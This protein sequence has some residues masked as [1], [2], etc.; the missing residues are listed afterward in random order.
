MVV[1]NEIR[2]APML[3]IIVKV[4]AFVLIQTSLFNLFEHFGVLLNLLCLLAIV[5]YMVLIAA[6]ATE[7]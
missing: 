6:H 4:Y 5:R 7:G 2:V 3:F 1:W